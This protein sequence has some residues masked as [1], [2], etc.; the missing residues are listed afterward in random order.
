MSRNSDL[1][2]LGEIARDPDDC[3]LNH[4]V[5]KAALKRLMADQLIEV[6][7]RRCSAWHTEPDLRG[8][9]NAEHLRVWEDWVRLRKARKWWDRS[10]IHA[11]LTERGTQHVAELALERTYQ[12]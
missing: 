3:H 10:E 12:P 11:R 6:E 5:S 7:T 8:L 2:L 9:N 1:A 4:K